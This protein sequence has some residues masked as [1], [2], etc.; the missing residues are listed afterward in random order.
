MA[1]VVIH[2]AAEYQRVRITGPS[3]M[4]T[5]KEAAGSS[6]PYPKRGLGAVN[7]QPAVIRSRSIIHWRKRFFP[8]GSPVFVKSSMTDEA[9]RMIAIRC[10]QSIPLNQM[11]NQKA[12]CSLNM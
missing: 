12:C 8:G 6:T 4:L 11:G 1:A 3:Q 2:R 5:G 10:C 9:I 7:N